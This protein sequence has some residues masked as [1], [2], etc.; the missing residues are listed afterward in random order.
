MKYL[1]L[2]VVCVF[3]AALLT[4][5][6][7]K[8]EEKEDAEHVKEEGREVRSWGVQLVE[9]WHGPQNSDDILVDVS[10][11]DKAG[12]QRL[13]A[14]DM[15]GPIL[16]FEKERRILSCESEDSVAGR[17]PIVLGLD[18]GTMDGPEHPGYLRH[19]AQ[20]EGSNLA[21]FEYN[22]VRDGKPYNLV[23]ILDTNAKVVLEKELAGA[24]DVEVR[25]AERTY[26]VHVPEP[27]LPG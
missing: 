12:N 18:G 16:L 3:L 11:V 14:K 27:E 8:P 15:V 17:G 1:S 6:Q 22:L 10:V 2:P 20:I 19:C 24:G 23:R 25:R 13:L 21:V 7:Q 9:R 26:R 5:C 4:A